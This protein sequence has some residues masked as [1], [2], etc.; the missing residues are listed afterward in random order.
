MRL[1]SKKKKISKQ[2]V[3]IQKVF[4]PKQIPFF[5]IKIGYTYSRITSKTDVKFKIDSISEV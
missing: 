4:N 5:K 1:R 3:Q 2:C